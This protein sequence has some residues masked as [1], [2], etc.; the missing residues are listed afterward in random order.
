MTCWLN[1]LLTGLNPFNIDKYKSWDMPGLR[2]EPAMWTIPYE[3]RGSMIVFLMLLVLGRI[4]GLPGFVLLLTTVFYVLAIGQWDI[5]LFL[6]GVLCCQ[7]HHYLESRQSTHLATQVDIKSRQQDGL[8]SILDRVNSIC[9]LFI[10]LYV[11]TIP[12]YHFG[13]GD[14][15]FYST[16]VKADPSTWAGLPDTGRFPVCIATALL[17]FYLGQSKLF[18]DLLST[19]FPQ[20]LGENSFAIYLIHFFLINTMGRPLMRGLYACKDTF[21]WAE[22]LRA[23][24]GDWLVL[25]LYSAIA[26]PVLF[27][28]GEI[29]T[30]YVDKKSVEL[31]RW[32]EQRC[33]G[34]RA[35]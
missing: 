13:L 34:S 23:V 11:V 26:V 6:S 3:Y 18:R 31:A 24:L 10:I 12:D 14:I 22:G 1:D 8:R 20:Y 35:N 16:I 25:A 5:F 21:G 28:S 15:P 33:M 27:W 17:V 9:G 29:I 2:Y 30:R 4:R 32:A 7:V 19:R